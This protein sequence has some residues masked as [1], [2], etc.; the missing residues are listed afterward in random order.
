MLTSLK[1]M[2]AVTGGCDRCVITVPFGKS[3]YHKMVPGYCPRDNSN[4]LYSRIWLQCP[5]IQQFTLLQGHSVYLPLRDFFFPTSWPVISI[6]VQNTVAKNIRNSI[7][8]RGELCTKALPRLF[9][10]WTPCAKRKLRLT[11]TCGIVQA[12]GPHRLQTRIDDNEMTKPCNTGSMKSCPFGH[13][14]MITRKILPLGTIT[15][16]SLRYRPAITESSNW[17]LAAKASLGYERC[18]SGRLNTSLDQLEIFNTLRNFRHM[19]VFL[20]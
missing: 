20:L 12:V 4:N 18:Q 8:F 11:A 16:T 9:S 14:A 1:T 6:C 10:V 2:I 5:V 7:P 17:H 3:N 13:K 19:V 15:K